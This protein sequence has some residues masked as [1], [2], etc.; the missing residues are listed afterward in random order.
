MRIQAYVAAM[1]LDHAVQA[2]SD[3]AAIVFAGGTDI[4]P[5]VRTG[6]SVPTVVDVKKLPELNTLERSGDSWVI[7][8]AVPCH[9]LGEHEAL[10]ADLPGLVEAA[11]LIGS[12]QIQGRASLG[13]NVGNASP[14]AD[15][16]PALIANQAVVE[17]AGPNGTR[18]IPMS[19][20]IT[21]PGTTSLSTGELIVNFQIPVVADG[22]DAAMRFTPRTEM[23]IAV[24]NAAVHITLDETG[25]CRAATVAIGGVGPRAVQV[26]E[27]SSAL[28]GATGLDDDVLNDVAAACRAAAS[29]IDDKRG[30]AD[31]RRHAI[32]VLAVRTARI[33]WQRATA[34]R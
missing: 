19:E 29:P 11:T 9:L 27:A 12:T 13:G 25:R 22:A 26:D 18:H 7:G 3:D 24:A 30:T 31:Y 32:G 15:T 10:R 21:G 34:R 4:V 2:L 8:A 6:R 23:D 1:S 5:Q 14:A 16:V 28:V 33:A 17:I 20:V